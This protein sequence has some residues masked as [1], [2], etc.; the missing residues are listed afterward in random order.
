LFLVERG[1][2]CMSI[3]YCWRRKGTHP[4]RPYCWWKLIHPGHPYFWMWKWIHPSRGG[5]EYHLHVYTACGRYGYTLD[6][7]RRLLLVLLLLKD[8]GK[9]ICNFRNVGRP[10]TIYPASA[11]LPVVNCLC[12]ASAFRHQGVSSAPLV[13]E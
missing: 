2:P 12:P 1:T 6:V 13:T 8:V 5:K 4:G 10:E 11:F 9:I 3:P 7:P